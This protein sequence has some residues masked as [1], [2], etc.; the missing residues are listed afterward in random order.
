MAIPKS[1]TPF[2]LNSYDEPKNTTI[3]MKKKRREAQKFT[4]ELK[5]EDHTTIILG[6]FNLRI[7]FERLS[8]ASIS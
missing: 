4:R 7:I 6:K 8:K 3:K 1:K 5:R 2:A